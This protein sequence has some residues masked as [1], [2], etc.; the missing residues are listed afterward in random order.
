[1]KQMGND[2]N[3]FRNSLNEI[4]RIPVLTPKI[5]PAMILENGA[6]TFNIFRKTG[7]KTKTLLGKRG[8]M[9]LN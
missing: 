3:S 5:P 4:H 1:M 7:Q 8:N 2:A 6:N 9:W